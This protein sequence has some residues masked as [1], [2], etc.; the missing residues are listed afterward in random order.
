MGFR[1]LTFLPSRASFFAH[2][3]RI[4]VEVKSMGPPHVLKVC[5]GVS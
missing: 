5:L 4:V 2:F 3:L 1:D